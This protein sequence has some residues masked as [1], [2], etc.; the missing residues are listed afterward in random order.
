MLHRAISDRLSWQRPLALLKKTSL[1]ESV[2]V[3]ADEPRD[4][5][6]WQFILKWCDKI[7][8]I[9]MSN[10]GKKSDNVMILSL[11]GD[12]LMRFSSRQ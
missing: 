4:N 3:F 5:G 6:C 1:E 9:N 11:I 12:I 2:Q 10:R 8:S 7:Q